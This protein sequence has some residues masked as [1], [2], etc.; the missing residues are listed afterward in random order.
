MRDLG[1]GHCGIS[2]QFHCF[3]RA[4]FCQV[5]NWRAA[6]ECLKAPNKRGARKK[7]AFS[8]SV[9]GDLF[10]KIPMRFGFEKLGLN[11]IEAKFIEGNSSSRRVMEK[12]GMTFEGYQ[13]KAMFIKGEYKT[14]GICSILREEFES[15][16]K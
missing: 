11:R 9:D 10:R 7:D 14:I 13:R 16:D 5:L 8:Q 12:T 1:F 15:E 3:F 4:V 6:A 2:Q